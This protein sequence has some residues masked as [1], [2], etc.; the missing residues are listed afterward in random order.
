MQESVLL[1]IIHLISTLTRTGICSFCLKS[2]LQA[3]LVEAA[4]TKDV[5]VGNLI[6]SGVAQVSHLWM[7]TMAYDLMTAAS[8]VY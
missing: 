5:I 6:A 7:D 1:G 3:T 2:V 4:V 8:F